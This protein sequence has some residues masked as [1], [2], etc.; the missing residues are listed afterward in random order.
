MM[1]D[2]KLVVSPHADDA[3][4]VLDKVRALRSEIPRLTTDGLA[5]D[6]RRLT[7]SWCRARTARAAR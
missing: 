3:K 2:V 6:G 4:A 7:V 5:A 1:S